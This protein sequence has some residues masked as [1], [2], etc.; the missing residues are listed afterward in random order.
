MGVDSEADLQVPGLSS[1][2]GCGALHWGRAVHGAGGWDVGGAQ[3]VQG[4]RVVGGAQ[5]CHI[6]Q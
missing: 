2:V 1:W 4:P 5:S 3:R 6:R